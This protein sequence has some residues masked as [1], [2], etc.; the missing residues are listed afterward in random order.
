MECPMS[1]EENQ[2]KAQLWKWGK[3]LKK[4]VKIACVNFVWD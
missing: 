1:L 2:K 3:Y 4:E